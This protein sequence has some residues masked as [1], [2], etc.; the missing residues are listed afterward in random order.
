MSELWVPKTTQ[1]IV[2]RSNTETDAD[3]I[4]AGLVGYTGD[5][6]PQGLTGTG[7]GYITQPEVDATFAPVAPRVATLEA[8]DTPWVD[9]TLVNSWAAYGAPYQAP[10]YRRIADM[11]Y[12]QGLVKCTITPTNNTMATL[13]IGFRPTA[14][15]VLF[16]SYT[17]D[18][19][20]AGQIRILTTGAIQRVTGSFNYMTLTGMVFSLT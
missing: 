16:L 1:R 19:T 7:E 2:V 10:R 14:G 11:V 4:D 12:L 13:P 3:N 8:L 5:Q 17:G 20:V 6:G 18:P 9:L 15:S